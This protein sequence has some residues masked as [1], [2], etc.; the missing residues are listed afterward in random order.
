MTSCDVDVSADDDEKNNLVFIKMELIRTLHHKAEV[1][2]EL[3]VV[4]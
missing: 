4:R 3:H 1:I 2:T